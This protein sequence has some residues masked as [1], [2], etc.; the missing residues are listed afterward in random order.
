MTK[1]EL[2]DMLKKNAEDYREGAK[3][4]LKRNNHMN[5]YKDE[6]LPQ[7]V[8]D[9]LLVD[10]INFVGTKQCIDYALYTSDLGVESN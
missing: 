7:N 1:I 6:E 8:I 5:A 4:S 10:F 2:L 9:A 3:D